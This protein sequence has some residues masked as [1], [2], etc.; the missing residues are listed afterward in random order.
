MKSRVLAHTVLMMVGLLA[1]QRCGTQEPATPASTEK[2]NQDSL[3]TEFCGDAELLNVN[4]ADDRSIGVLELQND[5]EFLWVTVSPASGMKLKSL[6]AFIGDFHQ[7][8]RKVTGANSYDQFPIQANEFEQGGAWAAR[9]PLTQLEPC[10]F[11]ALQFS[12]ESPKGILVGELLSGRGEQITA[13]IEYCIRQCNHHLSACSLDDPEK[14]PRTLPQEEWVENSTLRSQ[15]KEAFAARYPNGIT[16]G[17][18][19]QIRFTSADNLLASLPMMGKPQPL[20]NMDLDAKPGKV[21]NQLAGELLTLDLAIQLDAHFEG[22]STGTVPLYALEITSG[23]FEDWTLSELQKEANIVLGACTSNFTPAQITE[24][25][26]E[27]NANFVTGKE[28]G[29]ILRCKL[30]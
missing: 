12:V 18:N 7:C 15:I 5:A 16:I 14:L 2:G 30:Q 19:Q 24:V 8:P 26:H 6:P 17:C 13:G 9:I 28:P 25:L 11:A 29:T 4:G 3:A 22:F 23:A 21:D 27:V 20:V 1:L 10:V